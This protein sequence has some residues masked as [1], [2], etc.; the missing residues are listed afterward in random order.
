MGLACAV[1]FRAAF[2]GA[3]SPPMMPAARRKVSMSLWSWV[4]WACL[5]AIAFVMSLNSSPS[6]IRAGTCTGLGVGV[7]GF[8]TGRPMPWPRCRPRSRRECPRS[9]RS[10]G[11]GWRGSGAGGI[12]F[13][14]SILASGV[15]AAEPTQPRRPDPRLPHARLP[16][17]ESV[18]PPHRA[19]VSSGPPRNHRQVTPRWCE[20]VA[21]SS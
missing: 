8:I 6:P 10:G 7:P 14:P 17:A 15:G 5:A 9:P 19:G 21:L 2:A 12:G 18:A 13:P 3:V 11:F 20:I 16:T 1:A 4:I